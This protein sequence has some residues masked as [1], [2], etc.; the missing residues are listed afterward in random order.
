MSFFSCIV[1]CTALA[2]FSI[3]CSQNE[4]LTE[5]EQ[6]FVHISVALAEAKVRAIDSSDLVRMHDSIYMAFSTTRERIS[7]QTISFSEQVE[8][9]PRV[10]RA[11]EDSL[12]D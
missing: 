3:G 10:F 4:S 6:Q 8:R 7:Q 5:D 12:N 2:C 9:A 1:A 11:I